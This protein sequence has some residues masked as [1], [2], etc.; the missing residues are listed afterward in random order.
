MRSSWDL[1]VCSAQSRGTER[2]LMAAAASQKERRGRAE[3]CSLWQRWG[4]REWHGAVSGEGQLGVK[5]RFFTRGWWAGPQVPELRE[6]VFGWSCV[7]P[8]VGLDDSH[9]SLPTW[10][11]LFFSFSTFGTYIVSPFIEIWL[12][13][14]G[15]KNVNLLQSRTANYKSISGDWEQCWTA[16]HHFWS[17]IWY[18]WCIIM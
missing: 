18:N 14:V 11:I 8:G 6:W 13:M 1:W 10:N 9:G 2:T 12:K 16:C 17:I 7:K 5:G 3:F 4:T 15:I